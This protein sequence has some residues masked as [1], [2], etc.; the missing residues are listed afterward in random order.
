MLH[1]SIFCR[2]ILVVF[3]RNFTK[4]LT[5]R[6][7]LSKSCGPFPPGRKNVTHHQIYLFCSVCLDVFYEALVII[8]T[9]MELFEVPSTRDEEEKP[10]KLLKYFLK[11]LLVQTTA[12]KIFETTFDFITKIEYFSQN[13]LKSSSKHLI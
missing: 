1:F 11:P 13:K 12:V 6:C 2:C 3:H 5:F 9:K 10:W 4:N 7:F 8:L